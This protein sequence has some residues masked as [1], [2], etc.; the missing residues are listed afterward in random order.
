[1][2]EKWLRISTKKVEEFKRSVQEYFTG[3]AGK[4]QGECVWN[5]S[6]DVIESLFGSYKQNKTNN[7]LYGVTSYVLLLL[8]LTRAGSGKI[9]SK[10]NFKQALEKVFMRDLR[11]WK[12][13]HLTENQAI[14]RQVKLVG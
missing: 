14:K 4:L 3:E 6:S 10:V 1:M 8:L 7:S 5:A 11:E 12:E 9:A 13:T 2:L